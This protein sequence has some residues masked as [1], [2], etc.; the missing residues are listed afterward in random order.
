MFS[1]TDLIK[2]NICVIVLVEV[3]KVLIRKTIW[4]HIENEDLANFPQHVHHRIPNF[5]VSCSDFIT[6][7][8]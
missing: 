8:V 7:Y 2:H 3:T 5:K 6:V 4:D 1:E